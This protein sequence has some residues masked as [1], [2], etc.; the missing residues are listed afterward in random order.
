MQ[1]ELHHRARRRVP[2]DQPIR[3]TAGWVNQNF[4]RY[5]EVSLA[6]ALELL[7]PALPDSELP[8]AGEMF[9]PPWLAPREIALGWVQSV[10]ST[11]VMQ[12][13]AVQC[14]AVQ[15]SGR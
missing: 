10:N 3:C 12:C 6:D 11:Q 15:C 14:S 8:P 13:S 7:R 1:C 4:G 9:H 5:I 2:L